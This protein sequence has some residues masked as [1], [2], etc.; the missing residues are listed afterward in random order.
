MKHPN[1]LL[2]GAM[3]VLF[4]LPVA[5]Q[6]HLRLL[7]TYSTNTFNAS[8]SEI[9][10]YDPKTK[11]VFSTNGK[12]NALDI[13]DISDPATPVLVTSVSLTRYGGNPNHVA[14]QNGIVAVAV[15]NSVKTDPGMVVFLDTFG[16]YLSSVTVGAEPDMV[17]FTPD[18]TKLLVANEA[19]PND[20]CTID[21]EGSIS[22]INL[23]NGAQGLT[24]H[25]VKTADFK[26][27]TRDNID[28][29]I[30]IVT[31]SNTVAQDLEPEYIAVSPD[32]KTAW[33]TLQENNAI[34][35]VDID[36]AVIT[37]LVPLGFK[38]HMLPGNGLDPSDRDGGVNIGNWPVLGMYQPD[39]VAAYQVSGRTYL[40]TANEGD[41]RDWPGCNE[42]TRV[43]SLKLDPAAF[44]DPSIQFPANLGRLRVTKANGDANKD[45]LYE[46]LY[47]FGA[48]SFAIW[49]ADG[50]MVFESGDAFERITAAAYP[51]SFNTNH[52]ANLSFD[53]RSPNKGPEPE[54][55]AVGQ[56]GDRWYAFISL[57][58]IG[59]IMLYDITV[60][61]A[62]RFV[63]Y[64]NNRNFNL[65]T[66]GGTAGDLGPE[67]ILYVPAADS[68][69]S[70]PMLIVSNEVSG[71]VSMYQIVQ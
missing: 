5:G 59:G 71:T 28:P 3:G 12:N 46:K 18:G 8:G 10:A 22:I 23:A 42:E 15:E 39:H 17:V 67:G 55:L 52:T 61:A 66:R 63:E 36:N 19:E 70:K 69:N 38:D 27:F 62:P 33:V 54:G 49:D 47:A 6:I 48:R 35:I 41:A 20:R 56:L 60:P 31:A 43:S 11:R 1:I 50:Q 26:S 44:P 16:S 4:C 24:Q 30:R 51:D 14:V 9:S 2:A 45:G 65:S 29:R 32:S 68:P 21:P 58:R 7:G 37:R 53:A 64:V 34:A 57:E 40:V 13:I 25:D